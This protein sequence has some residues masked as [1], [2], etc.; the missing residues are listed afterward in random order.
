MLKQN[1]I[2]DAGGCLPN[3]FVLTHHG[4]LLKLSLDS[5]NNALP[6]FIEGENFGSN[7]C[8]VAAAMNTTAN[9]VVKYGKNTCKV[10]REKVLEKHTKDD[11]SKIIQ[12]SEKKDSGKC[13]SVVYHY[14][15]GVSQRERKLYDEYVKKRKNFKVTV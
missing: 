7:L 9:I 14:C 15:C 6:H 10:L 8:F 11:V 13:Q 4:G 12:I 5:K 3:G 1:A 2:D